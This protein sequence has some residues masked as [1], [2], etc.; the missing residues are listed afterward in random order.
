MNKKSIF[1]SVFILVQLLCMMNFELY[2]KFAEYMPFLLVGMVIGTFF[3]I[4]PISF[5]TKIVRYSIIAVAMATISSFVSKTS[6]TF[7]L[8]FTLMILLPI[9]FCKI[10]FSR[11]LLGT[12]SAVGSIFVFSYLHNAKDYLAKYEAQRIRMTL[13]EIN[14]FNPNTICIFAFM[15]FVFLITTLDMTGIKTKFWTTV[16]TAIGVVLSLRMDNKTMLFCFII[17]CLGI[18]II[19]TKFWQNKTRTKVIANSLLIVGIVFPYAISKSNNSIFSLGGRAYIWNRFFGLL[20]H[21]IIKWIFG[22]GG[23]QSDQISTVLGRGGIMHNSYLQVIFFFGIIT[24]IILLLIINLWIDK[25]EVNT[26][27][28]SGAKLLVAFFCSLI[29]G[30]SEVVLQSNSYI[31]FTSMIIAM[32]MNK[33]MWDTE[34]ENIKKTPKFIQRM[35]TLK[36]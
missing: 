10:N 24:F 25:M 23:N 9:L 4:G 19:P 8:Y 35:S 12:I 3:C 18:V 33:E 13:G 27:N 29:I 14:D 15:F 22:L 34:S 31:I 5:D 11:V 32:L 28:S 1:V 7:V 6:I 2:S 17:W 20:G 26:I 30:Y 16:C 21:D 36:G